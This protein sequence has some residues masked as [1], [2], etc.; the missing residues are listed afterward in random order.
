M[1][2]CTTSTGVPFWIEEYKI[3]LLSDFS[4][5]LTLIVVFLRAAV[6]VVFKKGHPRDGPEYEPSR[7]TNGTSRATMLGILDNQLHGAR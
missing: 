2:R 1:A 6:F 4:V 5:L 7:D 3:L